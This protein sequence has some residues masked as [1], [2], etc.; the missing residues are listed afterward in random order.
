MLGRWEL[1]Q[2]GDGKTAAQGGSTS[3]TPVDVVG[4][5]SGVVAIAAGDAHTCAVT[6]AGAVK[7][8]GANL[9]NGSEHNSDVA[10]EVKGLT[11]GM[12]AVATTYWHTCALGS[13]G[14]VECWGTNDRGQLGDGTTTESRVPV[15]VQ[16][17]GSGIISVAPGGYHTCA[18]TSA[19]QVKCWGANGFGQLGDGTTTDR[20]TPVEVDIPL[21]PSSQGP[22]IT[23]T[24]TR[25]REGT[26]Q[27]PVLPLLVGLAA[28]LVLLLR[29]HRPSA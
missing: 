3:E 22:P 14:D 26:G 29:P 15:K 23:A 7:C 1:G 5:D 18:L 4:L 9:A 6:E 16:A 25:G 8:W 20:L 12:T 24:S 27:P 13:G 11:A 2:L 17:L 28:L 10:V 21:S 19:G